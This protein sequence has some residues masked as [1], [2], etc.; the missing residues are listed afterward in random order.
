MLGSKMPRDVFITI[1]AT[2]SRSLLI[3]SRFNVDTLY[4]CEEIQARFLNSP[5]IMGKETHRGIHHIADI[6]YLIEA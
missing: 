4:I 3:H 5:K 1:K 6:L 2:L